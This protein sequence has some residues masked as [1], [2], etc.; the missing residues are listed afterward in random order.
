M[1]QPGSKAQVVTA[2]LGD[3]AW[4][5]SSHRHLGKSPGTWTQAFPGAPSSYP[6]YPHPTPGCAASNSTAREGRAGQKEKK[7]DLCSKNSSK[8]QTVN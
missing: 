1:G 4:G 3:T 7:N 8:V 5:A 2:G 6:R